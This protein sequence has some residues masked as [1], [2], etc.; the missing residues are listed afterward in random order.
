MPAF[1]W[2]K[3]VV[4]SAALLLAACGEQQANIPPAAEQTVQVGGRTLKPGDT[5]RDCDTCPELV[6]IP[7]GRFNM[8]SPATE[9]GH[10]PDEQP[11]HVVTF[12]K[13]FAVGKF[14]VTRGEY[15]AFAT[16]T[17]AVPTP[18]CFYF[19][20]TEQ[21]VDLERSWQAPG[22]EQSERDPVVCLDWD[23]MRAYL[24]WL[25]LRTGAEYRLLTEA[26]F[27]YVARAGTTTARPWG[28]DIGRGN[29]N[30]DGCGTEFDAKRTSPA[31]TFKANAFGAHDM[32]GNAW[33]R[34][35][36]CWH[37]TYTQ[38]PA[39]GRA[40]TVG[41]NCS[42]RVTRGGAWLSDA[43]D[44]RSALRNWDLAT[45]RKYTLGFRVARSL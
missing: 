27:E 23:E 5:F 16:A 20:G 17:N 10:S 7:A 33:E 14:E 44:V 31:G 40:W 18:G 36:D 37:D 42:Q 38:A 8:G 1:H 45:N 25:S 12:A 3:I 2:K 15:T 28:A 22:Y 41:G 6:V 32:L 21:V 11:Q 9:P 4:V 34:L 43:P 30:C 19:N 29:A 13:P 26:E 24:Q 35:E 39:D